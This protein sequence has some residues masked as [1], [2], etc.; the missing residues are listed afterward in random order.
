MDGFVWFK[1]YFLWDL[2]GVCDILKLG[3]LLNLHSAGS[4]E[5]VQG[6]EWSVVGYMLHNFINY[7]SFL[8]TAPL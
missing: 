6:R 5:T 3:F 1:G 2:G 4:G 7:H 8:I